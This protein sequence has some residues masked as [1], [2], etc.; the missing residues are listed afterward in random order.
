MRGWSTWVQK[1][2]WIASKTGRSLPQACF[3]AVSNTSLLRSRY[4]RFLSGR[5]CAHILDS[6]ARLCCEWPPQG[7][8]RE[9]AGASLGGHRRA[10]A[11]QHSTNFYGNTRGK[12]RMHTHAYESRRGL[13]RAISLPPRVLSGTR[14]ASSSN[15]C[16]PGLSISAGCAPCLHIEET[17]LYTIFLTA[18]L[19]GSGSLGWMQAVECMFVF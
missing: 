3:P 10:Q 13:A 12:E 5:W 2:T 11:A 15:A 1:T 18:S 7:S 16:Y 17:R 8:T 19:G 9:Q 4:D 6:W 14:R